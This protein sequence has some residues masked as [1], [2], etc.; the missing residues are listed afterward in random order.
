MPNLTTENTKDTEIIQI[1]FYKIII[2]FSCTSCSPWL[3]STLH[4]CFTL[5]HIY[6]Q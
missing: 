3:K 6:D 4:G 1:F 2:F 5:Q